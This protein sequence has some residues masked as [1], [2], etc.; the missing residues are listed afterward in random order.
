MKALTRTFCLLFLIGIAAPMFAQQTLSRIE[1][2]FLEVPDQ[3]FG[4]L[5]AYGLKDLEGEVDFPRERRLECLTHGS[6]SEAY[7]RNLPLYVYEKDPK[8]G[9]LALSTPGDGGGCSMEMTYWNCPEGGRLLAITSTEWG[10]C[11]EDSEIW[12][13]RIIDGEWEEVSGQLFPLFTWSDFYPEELDTEV[14]ASFPPDLPLV[15]RLPQKGKDIQVSL[16]IG[17]LEY[18]MN[19]ENFQRYGT[20]MEA[21][22]LLKWNN[23]SFDLQLEP[24]D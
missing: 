5:R 19:Q 11:C 22:Y 8:S 18:S 4:D 17:S 6:L 15:I 13:Y 3:V 9:F 10:M 1:R 23:C 21:N 24:Q 7:E 12:L 16:D 20:K 14:Q 2:F